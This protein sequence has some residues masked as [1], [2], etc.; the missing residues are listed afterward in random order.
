MKQNFLIPKLLVCFFLFPILGCSVHP[1]SF[2][3]TALQNGDGFGFGG[4]MHFIVPD[5]EFG[6]TDSSAQNLERTGYT[7][8]RYSVYDLGYL[9]FYLNKNN[10]IY[11]LSLL[12]YT[13]ALSL[14]YKFGNLA[15][16]VI[17]PTYSFYAKEFTPGIQAN[18][19]VLPFLSISYMI[20]RDELCFCFNSIMG[21]GRG[22]YYKSVD[23]QSLGIYLEVNPYSGNEFLFINP[24]MSY[25][26][27]SKQMKYTISIGGIY[28]QIFK[29]M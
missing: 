19:R 29:S 8:S 4:A 28:G 13:P 2:D 25:D 22:E 5:M 15:N 24:S 14:G 21:G 9:N 16:V 3:H 12:G 11:G 18:V 17:H 10:F 27:S 26:S 20:Y 1:P 23:F 6:V 7:E